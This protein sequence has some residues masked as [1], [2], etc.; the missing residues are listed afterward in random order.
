M[1]FS[2]KNVDNRPKNRW[3]HFGALPHSGG[4]W[5]FDLPK[6]LACMT[7][8]NE[9]T[10]TLSEWAAWWRPGLSKRFSSLKCVLPENDDGFDIWHMLPRRHEPLDAYQGWTRQGRWKIAISLKSTSDMETEI[11]QLYLSFSFSFAA[12]LNG[13]VREWRD[14]SPGNHTAD[15]FKAHLWKNPLVYLA[16][17]N[18]TKSWLNSSW[19]VIQG[20]CI[21]VRWIAVPGC[22]Q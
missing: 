3:L 10:H 6:M 1:Q 8:V 13:N 5:P 15:S 11:L 17:W 16:E 4:T 22:Y 12:R 20:V 7:A 2:E 19:L 21:R 14:G 9:Y 18:A